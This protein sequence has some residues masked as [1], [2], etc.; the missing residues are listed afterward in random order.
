MNRTTRRIPTLALIAALAALSLAPLTLASCKP[1]IM[2]DDSYGTGAGDTPSVL[3]IEKSAIPGFYAID[4]T[5]VV[6]A[7]D[8][9]VF[10]TIYDDAE[11]H[12]VTV[13]FTP[14]DPARETTFTVQEGKLTHVYAVVEANP[15]T[16][17]VRQ[18]TVTIKAE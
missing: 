15:I 10:E 1:S 11:P 5:V 14:D 6:F 8:V 9:N 18:T 4:G 3:V 13:S 2:A 12:L 7:E 16:V 17:E